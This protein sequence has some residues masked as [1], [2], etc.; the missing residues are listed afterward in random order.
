MV[1]VE[2]QCA[3]SRSGHRQPSVATP[4]DLMAIGAGLDFER[5]DQGQSDRDLCVGR[6]HSQRKIGCEH[7]RCV[8]L[9]FVVRIRN[10]FVRIGISWNP[11]PRTARTLGQIPVISDSIVSF[12]RERSFQPVAV[13]R[14]SQLT[15]V[16]ELVSL[17]HGV[18]MIPAMA[19]ECD[20]SDRRIYRS[21]S[22]P[23]PTRTV[24]VAWNPYR[25]QS[26]LLKSFR[27]HLR[28]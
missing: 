19:R 15:M 12:C 28:E 27:E 10:G 2:N 11:L 25:F 1:E 22:N 5:L 24:A 7:D 17:S 4:V 14:T 18:S 13:E 3:S 26:R 9:R 8:K 23:K 6:I 21:L 16:Q 20:D